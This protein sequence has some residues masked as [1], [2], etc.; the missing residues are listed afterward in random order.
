[1][2]EELAKILWEVR[3]NQFPEWNR[4]S[5]ATENHPGEDDLSWESLKEHS[6]DPNL[7]SKE[8]FR[9]L[10]SA[11]IHRLTRDIS[12]ELGLDILT[13]EPVEDTDEA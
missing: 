13:G 8:F 7:V 1:M 5:D 2:K 3:T 9:K 6:D 10:S 4:Y 12:K 11:I